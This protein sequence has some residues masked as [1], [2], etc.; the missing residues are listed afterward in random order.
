M[1]RSRLISPCRLPAED[2]PLRAELEALLIGELCK[3]GM[4]S[5]L[6]LIPVLGLLWAMVGVL[7]LV[8]LGLVLV[9]PAWLWLRRAQGAPPSYPAF[10]IYAGLSCAIG[11][12][13]GAIVIATVPLLQ[14]VQVAMLT[15]VII[16]LNSIAVV[17]M[18]SSPMV[19]VL[20]AA[21]N[22]L[23]LLFE[24]VVHPAMGIG[25]TTMVV[26]YIGALGMMLYLVHVSLHAQTLLGLKLREVALRDP[27]TGLRNRRALED[28]MSREV[29][30]VERSSD[31]GIMFLLVDIDRFKRVNDQQGHAAGD[32]VLRQVAELLTSATRRVDLVARWGG[33]EFLIVATDVLMGVPFPLPERVRLRIEEHVFALP[34]GT[35]VHCTCSIGVAAMPPGRT[36]GDWD[37]TLAEAD[38]ALYAAKAEGRNRVVVAEPPAIAAAA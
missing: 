26:I 38:R 36:T 10:L 27:L 21:W 23:A 31:R 9:R 25:F 22:L 19:Y 2:E 6:A 15:V 34:G 17:S 7:F 29:A 30:R 24:T 3:R 18:A 8:Q 11:L 14:P 20:H 28:A 37:R 33:E 32:A 12:T 4:A 16:G 35:Q 1:S 13:T 5:S